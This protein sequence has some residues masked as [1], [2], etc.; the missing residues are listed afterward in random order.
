[1]LHTASASAVAGRPKPADV[2]LN[3]RA[4]RRRRSDGTNCNAP[5]RLYRV[6]LTMC[7][8]TGIGEATNRALF[9]V[10][11]GPPISSV[12]RTAPARTGTRLSTIRPTGGSHWVAAFVLRG[13]GRLVL[14]KAGMPAVTSVMDRV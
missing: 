2:R 4:G 13:A 1:M 9:A 10:I 8:V 12:R 3:R 5:S 7:T 6:T 14:G 11:S